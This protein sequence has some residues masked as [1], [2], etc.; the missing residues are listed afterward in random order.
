MTLNERMLLLRAIASEIVPDQIV[1]LED[2][3]S[4]AEDARTIELYKLMEDN[5]RASHR[6]PAK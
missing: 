2:A 4:A 5:L 1:E 6:R 3:A